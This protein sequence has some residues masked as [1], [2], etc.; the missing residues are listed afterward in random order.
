MSNKC[1]FESI[2]PYLPKLI[3]KITKD[4]RATIFR[5]GVEKLFE[6]DIDEKNYVHTLQELLRYTDNIFSDHRK[7]A[8]LMCFTIA[9][10]VSSKSTRTAEVRLIQQAGCLAFL[11][12]NLSSHYYTWPQA[13]SSFAKVENI[14][15]FLQQVQKKNKKD[16]KVYYFWM[17]NSGSIETLC[18]P[19]A[20]LCPLEE[21]S[22]FIKS[23]ICDSKT[24]SLRKIVEETAV[25]S[26]RHYSAQLI[27][28]Y[29]E[30][31]D[32]I[33]A[34]EHLKVITKK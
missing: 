18:F 28:V 19:Q 21:K 10:F 1:C 6:K 8:Y 24:S 22:A 2:R 27:A 5:E 32:S 16:N 11:E 31:L 4:E 9:S 14:K 26:Y 15:N 17:T 33:L 29:E 25:N 3:G 13:H 12:R 34:E 20:T 30:A 7:F 23:Y